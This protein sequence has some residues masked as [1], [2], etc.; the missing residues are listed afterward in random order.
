M[1]VVKSAV[2]PSVSRELSKSSWTSPDQSRSWAN[3]TAP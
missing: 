2:L 3:S 1:A